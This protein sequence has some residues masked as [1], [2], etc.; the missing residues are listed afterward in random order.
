MMRLALLLFPALILRAGDE[1]KV[2][3]PEPVRT[4]V[5]LARA[6]PPE[7]FADT[8]LKLVESGRIRPPQLQVQFLN[9]AFAVAS[10]ARQKIRQVG[11]PSIQPDT[12]A[13]YR[14]KA[15][16]LNLDALSL[17]ARILKAMVTVDRPKARE[18][19]QHIARPVIDPSTCEDPLIPD[20]SAYYEAAAL[21]AQSTFTKDEMEKEGPVQF[22]AGILAGAKS[23]GELAP[24]IRSLDSVSLKPAQL[25]LLISAVAAK[26]E[27]VSA[28]YR[29]FA[30]SLD[31][32]NFYA[33]KL[34]ERARA[35][36][37]STI[38]LQRSLR[39]YLLNQLNSPRC[40][41]DLSR[42]LSEIDLASEVKPPLSESDLK[43]VS[44]QSS[45]KDESYHLSPDYQRLGE[46]L[47]SLRFGDDP[48]GS[49]ALVDFLRDYSAWQPSGADIDV[50]HQRSTI[51]RGIL[52]STPSGADRDR[53]LGV[54][55]Q[56]LR[57]SSIERESPAEWLWEARALQEASG[58]DSPKLLDAF[59]SSGNASLV[60]IASI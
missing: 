19:F 53:V 7:F 25:E 14:K 36:R 52:Q 59:R 30:P 47:T 20:A 18:L 35:N 10:G 31:P 12:P 23:P 44:R 49:A 26:L 29:S 9:E 28:D 6:A 13:I 33:L 21:I 41:G 8:I 34:I 40:T 37:V 43:P 42:P 57:S 15:A 16:E 56:F 39:T 45:S 2:E 55:V 48:K 58:A 54:C 22:L 1:R 3:L 5:E 17:Q 51:L 32:L 38:E 60:L 46:T 24:F 27:S 4:L 11:M 50:F